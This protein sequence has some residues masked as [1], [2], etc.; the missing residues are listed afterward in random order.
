M[1]VEGGHLRI[2]NYPCLSLR[3]AFQSLVQGDLGQVLVQHL[4]E[5]RVHTCVVFKPRRKSQRVNVRLRACG[6]GG[7]ITAAER[8]K[9]MAELIRA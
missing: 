8:R 4:A 7:V 2:Q 5:W 1:E 3:S 9:V 6:G